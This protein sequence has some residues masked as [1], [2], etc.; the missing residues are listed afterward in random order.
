[1][2]KT[3]DFNSKN[4][5]ANSGIELF[6]AIRNEIGILVSQNDSSDK[7]KDLLNLLHKIN[8]E[9]E[10]LNKES[11]IFRLILDAFDVSDHAM[12]IYTHSPSV[13][14]EE[15]LTNRAFLDILKFSESE[16]Q[17]FRKKGG[18]SIDEND[19]KHMAGMFSKAI[20]QN[21]TEIKFTIEKIRAKDKE[22][23]NIYLAGEFIFLK[24]KQTGISTAINILHDITAQVELEEEVKIY[25]QKFEVLEKEILLLEKEMEELGTKSNEIV[26][27]NS[28]YKEA[29]EKSN[30]LIRTKDKMMSI[31]AHD[32]RAPFNAIL[33]LS[34]AL[35]EDIKELSTDEALEYIHAIDDAAKNTYKL[36][37]NI[38]QWA[39]AQ[40]G[41]I[42]FNRED[43]SIK[44][45]VIEV[46]NGLKATAKNKQVNIEV[47]IDTSHSINVDQEMIKTVLRNLVD[48][49]I[50]YTN[51]EGKITIMA[52]QSED[53]DYIIVEDNGVGMTEETSKIIFKNIK[54]VT[55]KGTNGE[56]GTGYGL[57]LC[58]EFIDKHGGTIDV[59]SILGEGT[60]F[61][62]KLPKKQT[63]KKSEEIMK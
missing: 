30:E 14:V 16:Y 62:I 34:Q 13:G 12:Q 44:D 40:S 15:K 23:N 39:H 45:L 50:K 24:D 1:L 55:K 19:L 54:N 43:T 37:V 46:T 52:P 11:K 31:I 38:L 25:K 10:N 48:N 42:E 27:E 3:A 29:L 26:K 6:T 33:G 56:K 7:Y 32:L 21:S 49:S 47:D 28:H 36:L 17:E 8:P 41:N 63:C 57:K 60:K 59:E 22:K 20:Q 58:K 35:I 51:Q 9:I 2:E 53:F 18:S 5:V 4:I 61:T